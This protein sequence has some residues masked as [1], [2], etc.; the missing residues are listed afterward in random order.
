LKWLL[1]NP[2]KEFTVVRLI[3]ICCKLIKNLN[4]NKLFK[5]LSKKVP[6]SC[7]YQA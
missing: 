3:E 1:Y 5:K 4:E 7:I 2:F 6:K